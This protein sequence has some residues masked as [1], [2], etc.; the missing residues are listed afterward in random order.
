MPPLLLMY[1]LYFYQYLDVMSHLQVKSV[2]SYLGC[3]SGL[4]SA[5][6]KAFLP[7]ASCSSVIPT[8]PIPYKDSMESSFHCLLV[9]NYGGGGGKFSRQGNPVRGK[10]RLPPT[11]IGTHFMSYSIINKR[12]KQLLL[13]VHSVTPLSHS[14]YP[15]TAAVGRPALDIH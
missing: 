7:P 6:I 4:S 14:F 11:F 12:K 1:V 10:Y 3:V 2:G 15:A 8:F 13:T 9:S 5:P